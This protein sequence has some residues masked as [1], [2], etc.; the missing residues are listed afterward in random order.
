IPVMLSQTANN[1][2]PPTDIM[3]RHVATSAIPTFED[4]GVINVKN[5]GAKGDNVHD[6]TSAIQSAIDASQAGGQPV[7]LPAGNYRIS[8]ITLHA[9]TKLIG[10]SHTNTRL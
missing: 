9:N 1:P 7:F 10:V 6:D 5:Y 8:T 4:P 3:S 2:T